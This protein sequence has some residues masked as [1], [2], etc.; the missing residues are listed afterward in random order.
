MY[1]ST[2]SKCENVLITIMKKSS[3]LKFRLILFIRQFSKSWGWV[4]QDEMWAE[5]NEQCTRKTRTLFHL[6]NK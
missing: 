2:E 1:K 4:G 3:E 5:K 6:G